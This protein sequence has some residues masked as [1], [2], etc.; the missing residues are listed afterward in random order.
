MAS[1]RRIRWKRL[2]AATVKFALLSA[3]FVTV[4]LA[5]GYV[6]MRMALLGRQV[7]VPDVTGMTLAQAQESLLAQELFLEATT[8]R[9]DDR[10]ERGRILA[11][12]P[13]AGS[14]I[15]KYRKVKVVTSLG[16]KV[17]K[18]P[19]ARGQ[20]LRSARLLLQ[21]E[22]LRIGHIAYAFAPNADAD[23]VLSQDPL[24]SGESLGEGGVSLLVSKGARGATY[25]MPDLTGRA[26]DP[27]QR[28][29]R[30]RGLKIG[31]VR[32]QRLPGVERGAVARQYPE[33]GYPVGA[34]DIISLVVGE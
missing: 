23:M 18:V 4:L 17:F 28:S 26:A 31:S 11:Q 30:A 12:E 33:A 32:R 9:N 27:V 25:V 10:L 14:P 15:K 20:S 22:G 8:Q 21:G 29:L 5:S 34:G 16:P 2:A 6:A 13:G 19:D 1:V 24:P 3:A 7:T